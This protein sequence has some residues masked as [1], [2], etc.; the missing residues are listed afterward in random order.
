MALH[1]LRAMAARYREEP[2]GTREPST[3][4]SDREVS[5][6]QENRGLA[7]GGTPGTPGTVEI[8]GPWCIPSAD[9]AY[10][11]PLTSRP[12]VLLPDQEPIPLPS[13]AELIE[14]LAAAMAAPRP[15]QQTSDRER[16]M[17]YY[18]DA[19]R[20]RLRSVRG[21]PL[22]CGLLVS[23][24]EAMARTAARGMVVDPQ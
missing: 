13:E 18:R 11:P 2:V 15:W 14:A 23:S 1:D 8:V 16:A 5:T 10:E 9:M 24:E 6:P 19:A 12:S 21:D 22:A 20:R 4:G 17:P 7:D 3:T